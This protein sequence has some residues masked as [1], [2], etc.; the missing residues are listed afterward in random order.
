MAVDVLGAGIVMELQALL[1]D[2]SSVNL[3][4]DI[5]HGLFDDTA[6]WSYDAIYAWWFCLRL[7]VWPL[8]TMA[9]SAGADEEQDPEQPT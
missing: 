7:V 1:L 2:Q 6:A 3:R 5:A 9:E 4:N 8:R